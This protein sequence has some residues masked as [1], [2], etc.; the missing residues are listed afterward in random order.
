MRK[1]NRYGLNLVEGNDVVN[2]LVQD[3]PNYEVIDE[4]MGKNADA[5]VPLAT[6]LL[7]GTVHA[8]T[9]EN[10]NASMFRFVA[11]ANYKTG[12]TFTVDGVQ[13]TALLT[14]GEPLATGSY[15]IN[16]NVL[17]CLVGTVLTMFCAN[18]LADV[19]A[20]DSDKL[21]GKDAEYYASNKSVEEAVGLA[22]S[23][24]DITLAQ[25]KKVDIA[26]TTL[27]GIGCVHGEQTVTSLSSKSTSQTVAEY[28]CEKSGFYFVT[29]E[30]R[31]SAN[32][33][34]VRAVYIYLNDEAV[35]NMLVTSSGTAGFNQRLSIS[36]NFHAN[37]GDV[38]TIKAIQDS[39]STLSIKSALN[40]VFIPDYEIMDNEG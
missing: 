21:G 23:A 24:N 30:C 12:D 11:T 7:T 39:G 18:S 40:A 33:N 27:R 19:H 31:F 29:G 26:E 32:T 38:I 6:E 5:S 4:E 8:L 28:A 22:Q 25:Q 17:C 2:P 14:T 13:V 9:R 1:S 20:V 15:V 16:S 34:G 10:P 3:V 35:T 36:A 37:F